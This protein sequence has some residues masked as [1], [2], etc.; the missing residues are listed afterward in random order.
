MRVVGLP[1][2]AEA[3]DTEQLV[4]HP[5]DPRKRAVA[6]LKHGE[7]SR[8]EGEQVLPLAQHQ[9]GRDRGAGR[10]GGATEPPAD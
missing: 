9:S 3:A 4:E 2:F 10:V 6:R 1:D 7:T 5:I 8:E